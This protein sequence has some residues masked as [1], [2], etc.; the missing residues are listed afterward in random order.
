MINLQQ[1]FDTVINKYRDELFDKVQVALE[2]A[3]EDVAKFLAAASPVGNSTDHFRDH[4]GVEKKYK[5]IK[6]V[7]NDK[8]NN[9]RIPLTNLLEFGRKGR[10]FVKKTWESIKDDILRKFI[11]KMR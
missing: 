11:K 3:A 6:I 5:N 9:N 7:Y 10:P 1:Q 8:L 2:E 4:W